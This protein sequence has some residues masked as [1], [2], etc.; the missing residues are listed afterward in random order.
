MELSPSL[1]ALHRTRSTE[2]IAIAVFAEPT[3][4]AGELAGV[5][6]FRG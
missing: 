2:V 1:H 3:A 4:L 6:A 5:L